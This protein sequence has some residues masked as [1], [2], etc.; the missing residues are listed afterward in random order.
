MRGG[1]P[2]N[3][4]LKTLNTSIMFLILLVLSILLSLKAVLTQR[5]VLC[6]AGEGGDTEG[7][8]SPFPF[9][10]AAGAIAI[11]ALGYFFVL[12]LRAWNEAVEKK[13]A[14]EVCLARVNLWASL[15]VLSAAILRLLTLNAARQG[16]EGTSLDE[17]LPA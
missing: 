3:S 8:P 7:L 9:Q 15:F 1:D 16:S 2:E 5:E 4:A 6:A 12:S 11:G 10:R 14:E 13:G 17:D